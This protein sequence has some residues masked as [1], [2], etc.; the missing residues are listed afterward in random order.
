M[1]KY[2]FLFYGRKHFN[3]KCITAVYHVFQAS[4]QRQKQWDGVIPLV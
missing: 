1:C 4:P 2:Y 3:K